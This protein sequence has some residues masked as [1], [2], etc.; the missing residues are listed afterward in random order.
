[1]KSFRAFRAIVSAICAAAFSPAAFAASTGDFLAE[2]G[3]GALCGFGAAGAGYALY[4]YGNETMSGN[5]DNVAL[6]AAGATLVAAYPAAAAA[7]AY[8]TGEAVD[9]PSAN[10]GAAWGIPTL[11]AYGATLVLVGGTSAVGF[12]HVGVAADAV[13][14]P[15]LTA[16][17]YNL[18]KEPAPAG[19]SR[20]P[21]LEPYVAAARG[22]DGAPVPVYGLALYF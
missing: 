2:A 17:V 13:S 20:S 8:L 3:V 5:D 9:G 15:F 18:V 6:M 11:A 10:K 4:F 19:E 1:V 21:T 12:G 14:K 16:W 7:G 22:S